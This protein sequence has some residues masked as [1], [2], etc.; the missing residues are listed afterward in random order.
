MAQI[1]TAIQDGKY[2]ANM[3]SANPLANKRLAPQKA[4]NSIGRYSLA[5]YRST[6]FWSRLYY[7]LHSV[8]ITSFSMP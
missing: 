3:R 1:H 8:I 4:M 5:R 7:R 6:S 2:A